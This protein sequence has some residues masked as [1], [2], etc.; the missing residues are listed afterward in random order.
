MDRA[1][2]SPA[3]SDRVG[4]VFEAHR[5]YVESVATRYVGYADAPD[6]VAEVGLRLCQSLN[7]LRNPGAI[8]AWILRT[9]VNAARDWQRDRARGWR[10]EAR[11][12]VF[13]RPEFAVVDPDEALHRSDRAALVRRGLDQL[14]RS[15]KRLLCNSVGLDGVSVV[16][17][18]ADRT[19]TSRARAKLKAV[20]LGLQI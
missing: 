15:E 4:Q 11:I 13:D 2:L 18:G 8:R 20:L 10:L 9:T 16:Q 1:P 19:A 6:I 14:K 7:G 3:D 12:V 5:S 17:D